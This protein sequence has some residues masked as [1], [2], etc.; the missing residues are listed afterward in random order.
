M[1]QLKLHSV[2]YANYKFEKKKRVL[3]LHWVYQQTLRARVSG[4]LDWCIHPSIRVGLVLGRFMF[5]CQ[6][7]E[8]KQ[9]LP[10]SKTTQQARNFTLHIITSS[11][12]LTLTAEYWNCDVRAS[13]KAP[14]REI[15]SLY[16]HCNH[17]T[18]KQVWQKEKSRF[19]LLSN[20][21][22][23]YRNQQLPGRSETNL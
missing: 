2:R 17:H 9:W 7:L 22:A 5:K 1:I 3:V 4:D 6:D 13:L 12:Y 16:Y 8:F 21:S 23:I 19:K 10:K 15:W 14:T 20:I 18:I 11:S